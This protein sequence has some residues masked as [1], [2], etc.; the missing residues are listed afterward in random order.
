MRVKISGY[1]TTVR[2]PT[3]PQR[4]VFDGFPSRSTVRICCTISSLLGGSAGSCGPSPSPSDPASSRCSDRSFGV[5]S[6]LKTLQPTSGDL[7]T[8]EHL[9]GGFLCRRHIHRS[10]RYLQEE[11]GGELSD[12]KGRGRAKLVRLQL[13]LLDELDGRHLFATQRHDLPNIAVTLRRA[14]TPGSDLTWAT[15]NR[16]R[17]F[18]GFRFMPRTTQH[19]RYGRTSFT[20]AATVTEM[21]VGLSDTWRTLATILFSSSSSSSSWSSA[22]FSFFFLCC[23]F[24][25]SALRPPSASPPSSP[26]RPLPFTRR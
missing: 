5:R 7:I 9:V 16:L 22:T 3:S 14:L 25:L 2:L 26:W 15:R 24:P 13:E 21:A 17:A 18:P 19:T 12:T 1:Q 8:W 10:C 6:C 23:F 20:S 11:E 4:S